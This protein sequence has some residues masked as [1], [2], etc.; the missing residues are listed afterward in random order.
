MAISSSSAVVPGSLFDDPETA[1]QTINLAFLG[2]AIDYDAREF[3]TSFSDLEAPGALE[4]LSDAYVSSSAFEASYA[5]TSDE[6][7][8]RSVVFNL[9]DRNTGIDEVTEWTGQL[10]S[11]AIDASDLPFAILD[12][13]RESDIEAY[14]SKLFIADYVTATEEAG[15]YVPE[16]LTTQA[17]RSNA[18]LYAELAAL[19]EAS[20]DLSLAQV[21]TSLGGNPL[22]TATVGTGERE[23][24]FISQQ[25]GDE[26]IGT[27]AAM[28]FLNFL[29]SDTEEAAAIREGATITFLPRV[30]PDGFARWEQEA[31]GVRGVLD[32]R[33]NNEGQDLNRTYDPAAPFS[34]DVA[35]K[36]VAVRELIASIDP[37]FVL[38]YHGQGNYRDEDGNLDTMS[39]LW[40]TNPDVDTDIRDQSQRAVVALDQAFD[41]FDFGQLTLYPGSDNPAIARNGFSL[42][43]TPG[44]LVEQRYSQEMFAISEGLDLDY[45]ALR[46]ALA[47]QGF[48]TMKGL[49]TAVA[50]GSIDDLDPQQALEIP[51]RSDYIQYAD[52]Y[53]DDAYVSDDLMIA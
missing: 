42:A 2:D 29:T 39:V 25:H 21:G 26:P 36:S 49:A 12:A 53:S 32:P 9:F 3:L 10:A 48:I 5:A 46:S 22:Y 16:T 13:A 1:A 24:V 8:V 37:D 44:V 15:G 40:P 31:G 45:S 19:D 23:I 14:Q 47:L 41:E 52:L 17:L 27:E 30:N 28:H 11:G 7:L 35:P 51:D 20:E 50:D 18:E 38:D 43:G 34:A 4:S 6:A 33:V